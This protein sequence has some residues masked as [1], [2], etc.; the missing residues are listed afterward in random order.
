[1]RKILRWGGLLWKRLYKKATFLLLLLMIPLLVLGYGSVSKEES[2][3]VTVALATEAETVD[4][5]T[6]M[7]W[8]DLEESNLIRY[9]ECDSE[10]AARQ[11]VADGEADTAWI[12][13]ENLEK[14]I[15]DFAAKR[16]SSRA[17]VTVVEP[18]NRVLLKLL[19]EVL[20]G[21]LFP[22][23]SEKVYMD[24]IRENAPELD[25]VSD[26]KLLQYYREAPM[27]DGLFTTTDIHGNAMEPEETQNY[28]MAPVRGM[29]AVVTVLAGLATAMYYIKDEEHGTF[30][31]MS[32]R[33]KPLVELGCQLISVVNVL[34]V[35]LISLAVTGQTV[36]WGREVLVFAL[37]ALCVSAFA[38]LVRRLTGG[39]RGLGMVTP[40]L[41]VVM[42]VV[43]PVFFDLGMLRQVQLLFPPTYF[44]TAAYNSSYL[45]Y[46]LCYTLLALLVCRILD[47]LRHLDR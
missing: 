41:V 2:G 24:Y 20:S 17:F 38:M 28:L 14:R 44:V 23:C 13:A 6:R 22:Y 3:V 47:H 39:M 21:T 10:E 35:V 40:I 1:M 30:S 45:L 43:C 32:Q 15:Y 11:M 16:V 25:E 46:M 5:L 26:E 4:A 33:R 31:C 9:M 37:Y 12:F 18:E 19:R 7:V 27:S 36:F 8:D 29:L 42:L 34:T